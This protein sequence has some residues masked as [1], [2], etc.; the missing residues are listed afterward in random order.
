MPLVTWIDIEDEST[1]GAEA[2]ELYATHR[3][4]MTK[5]VPRLSRITT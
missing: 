5:Q 2:K 4:P 1:A 3:H